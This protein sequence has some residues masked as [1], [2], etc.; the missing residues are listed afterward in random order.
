MKNL[1]PLFN[2][3][4]QYQTFLDSS[5]YSIGNNYRIKQQIKKLRNGE[6]VSVVCIGGSVTEGGGPEKFT[7]GYAYV[8]NDMLKKEF[9]PENNANVIFDNAGL[10]GTPSSLGLIRYEQDVIKVIGDD[11]DILVIEF[12]VNDSGECTSGRA[13]ESLIR[14]ALSAKSDCA[15]IALYADAKTYENTQPAMIPIASY[16]NIPQLSIQDANGKCKMDEELFFT[17]YAHPTVEGH[18]AMAEALINLFKLDEAAPCDIPQQIPESY[19]CSNPLSDF[20]MISKS[21]SEVT[22]DCG[23][24]VSKDTDTQTLKKTEGPVFD[25]NYYRPSCG[26]RDPFVLTVKCRIL[27]FTYKLQGSW[28]PEKFGKA[29]VFIDGKLAETYDGGKEGGWCNCITTLLIDEKEAKEHTVKI[30][31][32]PGDEDKGFTIMHFAYSK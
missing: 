32:A 7:D 3:E 27:L 25:T 17:D 2:T 18:K 12:S 23:S 19:F 20:S 4:K 26:G 28:L 11:P 24:F 9:C 6:R 8:F 30:E 29:Q 15:V 1:S 5:I 21:S 14:N 16:Y 13:F 10:S 31:M 22:I